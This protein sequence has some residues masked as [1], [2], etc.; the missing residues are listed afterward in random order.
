MKV[1]KEVDWLL[2]RSCNKIWVNAA[3][4]LSASVYSTRY[5]SRTS[6]TSKIRAIHRTKYTVMQEIRKYESRAIL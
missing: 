6:I 4:V 5:D 3:N 1:D 2:G